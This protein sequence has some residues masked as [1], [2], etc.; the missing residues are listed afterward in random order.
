[1]EPWRAPGS[2]TG[3]PSDRAQSACRVGAVTAADFRLWLQ[4]EVGAM[5]PAR[6]LCP[7]QQTF[8]CRCPLWRRFRLLISGG[9]NS[10]RS[11]Q[12]RRRSAYDPGCVKTWMPAPFAQEMNPGD[13]PGESLLRR[14]SASRLNISSR[15][16]KICFHTAWT[17]SGPSGES[18]QCLL[19]SVLTDRCIP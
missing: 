15:S 8:E 12:G 7:R 9:L 17:R 11:E 18:G 19:C 3:P 16:L 14:R 1:M 4:A 13:N 5:S 6:L 2:S 10:G